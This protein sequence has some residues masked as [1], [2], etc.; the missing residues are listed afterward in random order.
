VNPA[1]LR[2]APALFRDYVAG[3]PESSFAPALLCRAGT[4]SDL[5]FDSSDA[6]QDFVRLIELY[7]DSGYVTV[8]ARHLAHGMGRDRAGRRAYLERLPEQLPGTLAAELARHVLSRLG[9]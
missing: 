8:A 4:I 7:P 6:F 9:S 3:Y 1:N 5:F 2:D